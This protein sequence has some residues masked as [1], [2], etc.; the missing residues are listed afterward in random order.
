MIQIKFVF[1]GFE[2]SEV[3]DEINHLNIR[4]KSSGDI[5]SRILEMTSNLSFNKVTTIANVVVQS[6]IFLDALK[7]TVVSPVYKVVRAL[8]KV[9][10]DLSVYYLPSQN[11]F[12][13]S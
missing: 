11:Y 7:L 6:C 4:K 12:S 5:P 1:L 2:Y 9:T 10:I 13:A 3:S 8:R